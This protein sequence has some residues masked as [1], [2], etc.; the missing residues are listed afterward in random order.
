VT[1]HDGKATIEGEAAKSAAGRT[2]HPTFSAL[3]SA[4]QV[5]QK[6]TLRVS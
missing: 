5:L 4:G 6:F 1:G 3:N 2:F